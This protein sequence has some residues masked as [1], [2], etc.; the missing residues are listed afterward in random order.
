MDVDKV[1]VR[2]TWNTEQC[3]NCRFVMHSS[4]LLKIIHTGKFGDCPCPKC[5]KDFL[6]EVN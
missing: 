5:K 1:S 3:A 6:R 2:H 4:D